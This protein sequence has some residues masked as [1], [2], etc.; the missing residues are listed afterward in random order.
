VDGC[1]FEKQ[2]EEREEERGGRFCVG[3]WKLWPPKRR[4]KLFRV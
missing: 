4:K 2:A 3:D 1:A